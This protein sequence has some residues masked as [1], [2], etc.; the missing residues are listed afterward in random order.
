MESQNFIDYVRI[1]GKAGDGG[2][3]AVHFHREKHI[4]KG[5]PDGGDGGR[6]GHVGMVADKDCWT[7]LHLRY[8]RH[9]RAEHGKRGGT[10]KRHG[11]QGKD[12]WLQVPI[13]TVAKN[14]AGEPIGELLNPGERLCLL[15]GGKSGKGNAHFATPTRQAPDYA[16]KGLPG[17]EG[18]ITLEL[19]LLADVGLVGRPNAG[20]S[21]LLS[22][23]S[24]AR[25]KIAA[26]PFTTLQP[27]LG[28][29]SL[30][31]Y[32]SFVM[33]DLPGIISGAAEGKGLGFRFLRHIERN[34]VLL[35]VISSE[36]QHIAT[37]YEQLRAELQAYSPDLCQKKQALAISK[38]DL[39]DPS[40]RSK[41]S[42]TLPKKIPYY[43]LS[44]WTHEGLNRLKEKLWQ[45][46]QN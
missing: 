5:G 29:V 34:T 10:N 2:A 40:D 41:L 30:Q 31:T 6:G 45:T 39:L 35:F 18:T 1:Y 25:P 38:C 15:Q 32:R 22:R 7:L 24:A 14:E 36:E 17:E 37:A 19:K 4:S 11:A 42:S 26:Y 23:L 46:L 13:G 43:F 44:S 27:V 9:A 16:Q 3:G 8:R 12:L 20:K 33:A 28:L 21:T